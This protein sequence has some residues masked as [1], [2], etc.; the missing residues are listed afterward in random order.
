L[1]Y[2]FV[3]RLSLAAAV[4]LGLCA[5]A[6]AGTIE[7]VVAFPSRLVPSM[8]VYASEV[9]TSR[10]HTAPLARGQTSFTLE[11]PPGRYLL[12]L[13]PNEPGAPNVYG[14][15]TRYSLCTPHADGQCEDHT[16]VPVA[17]A[18]KSARIA[19]TI[20]D[21][22]LTDEVAAQIDRIRGV[23]DVGA[24]RDKESFGAPRF[25][26]Y[27]SESIDTAVAPKLDFSGALVSEEERE[28]VMRAL[29]AG[30]NFAGHLTAIV[31]R[32]GP[33]CSRLLLLDWTTGA[34]HG[35]PA[36]PAAA[37]IQG[38]PCRA[39][40]ALLTRRDS[41]LMSVSRVRGTMVVTQYYVW[42]QKAAALV[43]NA[44][45]QRTPQTFCAVAARSARSCDD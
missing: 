6:A 22:Y 17:V 37:E 3:V 19:V 11:L 42:N 32:C 8:T 44:E 31:T 38:L 33:G 41:R 28:M 45:Y 27:P 30:P 26:E 12:F 34:I 35:L 14:A 7:G 9:E 1:G 5:G 13:S 25:S 15:F 43:Q 2:Q 29:G 4:S 24:A 23:A 10:I 39:D 21:W 40:E 20:D 16:L 36:Q 18:A